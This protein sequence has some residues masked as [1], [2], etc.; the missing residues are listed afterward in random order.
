MW[1]PFNESFTEFCK[2]GKNNP[3]T[4]IEVFLNGKKLQ[5]LL[6]DVSAFGS[7]MNGDCLLLESAII[8]QYK[9][10]WYRWR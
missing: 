8:L 1:L 2:Q 5:L 4:L 6:G 10:L 9:I 3:G 7:V